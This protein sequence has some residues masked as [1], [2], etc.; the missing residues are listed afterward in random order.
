VDT[1]FNP[2]SY[3][4][5]FLMNFRKDNPESGTSD[6]SGHAWWN[7]Y[8]CTHNVEDI[9]IYLRSASL[10]SQMFGFKSIYYYMFII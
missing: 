4:L 1:S 8:I 5:E 7:I 3:M 10:D 2:M 9:C 6:T